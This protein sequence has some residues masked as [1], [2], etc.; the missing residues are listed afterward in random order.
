[1]KNC[2]LFFTLY[3]IEVGVFRLQ[4]AIQYMISVKNSAFDPYQ[5]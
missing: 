1:M 4:W 5:Y 3:R 2:F